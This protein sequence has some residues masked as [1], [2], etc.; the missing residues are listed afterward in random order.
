LVVTGH[1]LEPESEAHARAAGADGFM[2]KPLWADDV[3][4]ALRGT[5]TAGDRSA[6]PAHIAASSPSHTLDREQAEP[7]SGAHL[8]PQD[9]VLGRL[10]AR[11][12]RQA[13][14]VD[15]VPR[16]S[17]TRDLLVEPVMVALADPELSLEG[18]IGCAR[19][20]RAVLQTP[21]VPIGAQDLLSIVR[22]ASLQPLTP[23]HDA[24]L[25][26]L[27]ILRGHPMRWLEEA[28]ADEVGVSR[29]HF[30]RLVHKDTGFEYRDFL[31]SVLMKAAVVEVLTTDEQIAQIAY[32]LRLH[33]GELDREFNEIFG[34][35]P[36]E[37]RRTCQCIRR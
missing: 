12:E 36:R 29:A 17:E 9:R 4:A 26:A 25:R 37:L 28:L 3:A 2:F 11:L 1:Y 35:S 14:R 18:F 24:V 22:A 32:R 7:S 33:P 10:I 27:E 16:A 15:A 21:A 13:I 23:R 5:L 31:R 8:A 6:R 34:C 20:L 30:G 19:A